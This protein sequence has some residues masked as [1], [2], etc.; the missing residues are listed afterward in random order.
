MRSEVRN[1][2][3]KVVEESIDKDENKIYTETEKINNLTVT[4]YFSDT[5]KNFYDKNGYK[6]GDCIEI[7]ENDSIENYE[8]R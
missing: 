6:I 8:E 3:L 4:T 5:D 7:W 2:E 1:V